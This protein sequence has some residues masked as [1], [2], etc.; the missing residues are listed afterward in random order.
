MN[1]TPKV[2]VIDQSTDE[3][4]SQTLRERLTAFMQTETGKRIINGTIQVGTSVMVAVVTKAVVNRIMPQTCP[5]AEVSDDEN[6]E[7]VPAEVE[8]TIVEDYNPEQYVD[9]VIVEI[10]A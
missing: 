1:T 2:H 6:V 4:Q 7:P 3:D 5:M 8:Q 9:E 10:E